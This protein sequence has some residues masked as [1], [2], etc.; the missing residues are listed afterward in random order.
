MESIIQTDEQ[1]DAWLRQH[2]LNMTLFENAKNGNLDQVRDAVQKGADV[3]YKHGNSSATARAI[4]S[5]R[6]HAWDVLSWQGD[7]PLMVASR[8]DRAEVVRE[9]L[10]HENVDVNAKGENGCTPLIAASKNRDWVCF[11]LC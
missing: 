4:S 1:L 7:T 10:K 5:N 2:K 6:D 11:E 9:L 8:W 3:T